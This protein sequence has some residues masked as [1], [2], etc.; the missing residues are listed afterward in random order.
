M[1]RRFSIAL[2]A[3]AICLAAPSRVS[4]ESLK[5][6]ENNFDQRIARANIDE[7][8]DLLGAT[9]G[10]Y[11]DGIGAVFSSEVNLVAVGIT[12]FRPKLAPEEIERLRTRKLARLPQ[13][14]QLMRDMMV[15]SATQLKTVPEQEQII[16]GV[17]IFS[18]S[19]E[20][21][22]DLPQQVVMRSTRKSLLEVEAGR[23]K[24]DT[25]I[26]EQDF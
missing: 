23:A 6:L 16:V 10:V 15:T 3:V 22:K 8:F 20:N 24:A 21:K 18:Y 14:K 1:I 13:L 4:R 26:Q 5:A 11:V 7:P 25:A 2:A 12:P 17:H 9:R 19:W